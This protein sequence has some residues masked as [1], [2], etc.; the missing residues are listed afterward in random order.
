MER[1]GVAAVAA[2]LVITHDIGRIIVTELP[3]G[4]SMTMLARPACISVTNP[5]FQN[6]PDVVQLI[7]CNY[8][9]DVPR[10]GSF[11]ALQLLC[12]VRKYGSSS[13]LE[14]VSTS[15]TSSNMAQPIP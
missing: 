9:Y 2:M 6:S 14:F 12:D 11:N 10:F 1:V 13:F 7:P 4:L 8:F 3:I 5:D 15:S